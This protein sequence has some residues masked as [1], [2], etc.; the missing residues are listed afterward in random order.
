MAYIDYKRYVWLIDLVNNFDGVTFDDIDEA[1]QDEPELNPGG[2]PL[3]LR[4][5]YNH[6]K[7]IRSIFDIDIRRSKADG[8]YRVVFKGDLGP[9]EM[10]KA[11]MS[12]L[13]LNRLVDRHKG[14]SSRI[15]YEDDPHVYP[16]WM[17]TILYSMDHGRKIRLEYR[18]YGDVDS[19]YRV[20]APYCLKMFKRRWYLLAKEG[21]NLKTFALDDRTVTVKMLDARFSLPADFNAEA[22]FHDV[23]GIRPS[24]PKRVVLKAYGH[25]VDYL[26]SCPL[27]PSQNEE[28]RV[29]GYSIFSLFVG[30]DAW[31]FCQEILSRGSRIEVLEPQTLR[32]DIADLIKEMGERYARG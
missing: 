30:I 29:E 10:R 12:M 27:H 23:F 14:L 26:R 8:R 22:Y 15:L 4:T 19:S 25:E 18:K 2:E 24:P 28:E 9:G 31:E 17:S 11:L 5:F 21:R 13:S 20:L 16:E 3:P 7:A 32:E 1:W 6:I